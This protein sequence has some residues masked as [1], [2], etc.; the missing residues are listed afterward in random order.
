[1]SS[2]QLDPDT[3]DLVVENG[4]PI[5][6]TGAEEVRQQLR[7]NLREWYGEWFLDVTRGVPYLEEI[8]VKLPDPSRI[9]LILKRIILETPGVIELNSFEA[10][11]SS[12]RELTVRFSARAQDGTIDFNEVIS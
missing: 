1:M 4:S 10:E 9:D 7:L 2:W 6:I 5:V 3:N 12:D 8:F 11:L